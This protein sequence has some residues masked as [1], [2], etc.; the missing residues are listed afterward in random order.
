MSMNAKRD[1]Y[2]NIFYQTRYDKVIDC[3]IINIFG[4]SNTIVRLFILY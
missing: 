2:K 4:N 3:I 1:N